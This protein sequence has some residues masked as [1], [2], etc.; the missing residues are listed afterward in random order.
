M[1]LNKQLGTYLWLV[2]RRV[3]ANSSMC[4]VVKVKG[5]LILLMSNGGSELNVNL[6][7]RQ[8]H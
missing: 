1:T 4:E 8:K 5:L 7:K 2:A 6:Q 3:V